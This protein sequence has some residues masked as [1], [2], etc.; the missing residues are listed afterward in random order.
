MIKYG[1]QF[2]QGESINFERSQQASVAVAQ[3]ICYANV[4]IDAGEGAGQHAVHKS[5]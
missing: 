5:Q 4:M 3:K 2:V 1:K